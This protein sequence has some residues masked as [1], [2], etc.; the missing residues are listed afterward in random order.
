MKPLAVA[1]VLVAACNPYPV[2]SAQSCGPGTSWDGTQCIAGEAAPVA[3][4]PDPGTCP[5]GAHWDGSK[6]A[7]D[8]APSCPDGQRFVLGT[9]CVP[10][11]G[12]KHG[13]H[14]GATHVADRYWVGAATTTDEQTGL[15]WAR[16]SAKGEISWEEARSFCAHLQ[17]DG[18]RWRLPRPDELSSIVTRGRTPAVIPEA[19]PDTAPDQ[20]W[21]ATPSIGQ[22]M[23]TVSFKNGDEDSRPSGLRA[24]ARCVR[25]SQH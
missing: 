25:T 4:T 6:C 5:P 14:A 1:L 10:A 17:A 22:I 7:G 8:Q 9:G 16:E 3:S 11:R 24:F 20:Y 23:K 19:F 12:G 15:E 2:N 21:T 13:R 18:G